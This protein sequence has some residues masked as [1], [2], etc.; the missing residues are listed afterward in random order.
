MP[1]DGRALTDELETRTTNNEIQQVLQFGYV[2]MFAVVFPL[3]PLFAY[4]NNLWEFK[5]DLSQLVK[6][7]RPQVRAGEAEGPEVKP[8]FVDGWPGR[9]KKNGSRG[10]DVRRAQSEPSNVCAQVGP[11]LRFYKAR[12]LERLC[13]VKKKIHVFGPLDLFR[14]GGSVCCCGH[15]H[16]R[17]ICRSPQTHAESSIGAWQLCLEMIGVVACLTNLLLAVLV[18][19]NVDLYV[20][21]SMTEQLGSFEAKVCD[22]LFSLLPWERVL[23]RARRRRE[24]VH[25]WFVCRVCVVVYGF[26]ARCC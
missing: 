4:L 26:F 11:P 9:K 10:Y 8:R 15:D 14:F 24:P 21:K 3:A 18:S 1:L 5:L 16:R 13:F 12:A 25:P 23:R 19:E 6:T 17:S 20:P 7:R 22:F 2:S